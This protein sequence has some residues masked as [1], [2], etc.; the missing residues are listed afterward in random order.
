MR[1]FENS[2]KN[3]IFGARFELPI[4]LTKYIQMDLREHDMTI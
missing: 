4:S 3:M 2:T 1:A